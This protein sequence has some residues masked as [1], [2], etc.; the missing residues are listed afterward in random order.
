[1]GVTKQRLDWIVQR[2]QNYRKANLRENE[3]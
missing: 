2:R 1:M 3:F